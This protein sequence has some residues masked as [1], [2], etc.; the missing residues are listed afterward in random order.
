MDWP[1]KCIQEVCHIDVRFNKLS[2]LS[3]LYELFAQRIKR[4]LTQLKQKI[5]GTFSKLTS[6][7]DI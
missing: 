3:S 1:Y 6:W 5:S 7:L 4:L 2:H